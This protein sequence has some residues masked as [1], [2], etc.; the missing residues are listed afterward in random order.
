VIATAASPFGG[1]TGVIALDVSLTSTGRQ[2]I[3]D[4]IASGTLKPELLVGED[5][6]E[7]ITR[8]RAAALEAVA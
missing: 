1:E 2:P 6:A 5:G 3:L 7:A 8:A 4:L